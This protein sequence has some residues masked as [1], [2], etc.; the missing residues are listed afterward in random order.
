[1]GLTEALIAQAAG[2]PVG[3][4][5]RDAVAHADDPDQVGWIDL[6]GLVGHHLRHTGESARVP[7]G[8]VWP[9]PDQWGLAGHVIEEERPDSLLVR[10]GP[11]WRPAWLDGAAEVP[12]LAAAFAAERRRAAAPPGGYPADP[13]VAELTGFAHYTSPG[14]RGAIRAFF[15]SPPGST[16]LVNLPTGSG[17]S[18]V[19]WLP[20]FA[21][22]GTPGVTVV[23][24]PT[25]AL[26]IDQAR[27]V[28]PHLQRLR[29]EADLL[30][31]HA[32][33]EEPD[34]RII[35]RRVR[36]GRQAIVFA[37]PEAVGSALAPALFAAASA[38]RLRTFVVDEAHLVAQWGNEFRPEFQ[39]LP[40]LRDA[41]LAASPPDRRF[42]TALLSATLTPATYRTLRVLFG[43]LSAVSAV[44]L[45]PEP[46]YWVRKARSPEERRDLVVETVLNAPR[47]F[48]LYVSTQDAADKWA[49][50]LSDAGL[51]R[52]APFHGATGGE[53]REWVIDRWRAGRLD[54]VVATSAFGLGMDQSD[55]RLVLHAC[56]PETVDRFYQE[57]GRGGRDGRA[58]ASVLLWADEDH[59]TAAVL[60]R[61]RIISVDLGLKRWTSLF[62]TRTPVDGEP[63]C[64]R[65]RLDAVRP[66]LEGTSEENEAWNRRTLS[67]MAR[68]GLIGLEAD[69]PPVIEPDPE[70]TEEQTEARRDRAF[71]T[72]FR[73]A[74]VRIID[75]L[76]ADLATW[77]AKVE[78]ARKTIHAADEQTLRLMDDVLSGER[79]LA[80]LFGEV[81]TLAEA[82]AEVS[83]VEVCG[84]CSA[85]RR[86]SYPW[87]YS[88]PVPQLDG[89][90][91]DTLV[92]PA[93][94]LRDRYGDRV[95]GVY[96]R[97]RRTRA[98]LRR[99]DD[100][101]LNGVLRPLVEA[102]V[103]EVAAADHWRDRDDYRRLYALAPGRFVSHRRPDEPD[104]ATGEPAVPRVTLWEDEA[105]PAW[106][107]EL[108]RPFHLLLI[109]DDT[110]DP[111]RPGE[112]YAD[113]H[114][115]L[116]LP[117]LIG[118]LRR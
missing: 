104:A 14:Q 60:N 83:P 73:S 64:Y 58:C 114:Q 59:R 20:A 71:D 4:R 47:P 77:T 75:P 53:D 56:V 9:T 87:G 32:D 6:A 68:A 21:H 49:A 12:P 40:A 113:H 101:I 16:V 79:E 85:C 95:I 118:L 19:G 25:V 100:L 116:S 86:S 72:Y 99:W 38:G 108:P 18:A 1:M 43:E 3:D 92:G 109:P 117:N 5:L 69:P 106:L 82:G 62:D 2:G 48:L 61:E 111:A 91:S 52:V 15:A 39:A 63:S 67:L 112:R 98:D 96:A 105:P 88:L 84:G 57:V 65:V 89:I 74:R 13:A 41:L 90:G 51:K 110:P 44:H 46:S 10:A 35:K 37:S 8:G 102:G 80:E 81:Y 7:R 107:A 30:A 66:E 45:R 70:E 24:V 42:R 50:L 115:T 103:M 78:P 28:R 29:A 11:D 26:A 27:Q 23:I 54:A 22:A 94:A 34:R 31:W 33:L 55:V 17:K 93:A 97:P 76:H 36:S